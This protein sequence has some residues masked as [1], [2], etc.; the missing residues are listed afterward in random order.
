MARV[1]DNNTVWYQEVAPRSFYNEEDLERTIIH[2][3]QLIFTQFKA[4]P[5]KKDLLDASRLKKT[6]LI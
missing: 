1:I 6:S 4:L 5:F 3:L 2:N